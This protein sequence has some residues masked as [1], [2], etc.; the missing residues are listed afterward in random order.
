MNHDPHRP[1]NDGLDSTR[2]AMRHDLN[3]A[4]TA[5]GVILVVVLGLAIAAVFAGMR[6]AKNFERAEQAEAASRERLWNSYVAQARA[7][8]LTPQAG[9]RDA[10]L[11]VISN[12]TAI[13]RNAGLRSEA[14]ATLA[15]ADLEREQ[16][17][18]SMPRGVDQ[19]EMD[20]ALE[21]FAYGD[22]TGTVFVCRL[23]DNS[24]LQSL[25]VREAG[26]GLRQAVRS[27]AFSPD[28]TKLAA[29]F[30]GG[31]MAVWD[32][33]SATPLFISGANATNLIIAGMSFWPQSDHISFGDPDAQGLISIHDFT[34]GEKITTGIRVGARAFRFRPGTMQVAVATDNRVD[35]FAFPEETPLRTLEAAT[36]VFML[37]WTPAGDK[38]AVSTEDGDVYLWDLIRDN[39]RV[40]RGHSEPCIRLTFSPDGELLA[41]GSR[42]GTTRLWDVA[43]GQTLVLANEGL[44]HVFSADGERIGF[45][46]PSVGFGIWQLK[47]SESY[48]QLVCPKS[49][50]AFLSIDLSPSG[51]WCIATQAKGVRIWDLDHNS[52]EFFFPGPDFQSARISADESNLYVGRR[53]GLERW[54]L[55]PDAAEQPV[56]LHRAELLPL[57]DQQGARALAL[58]LASDL[59]LVE[60]TDLRLAIINLKTSA[61]PVFLAQRS[62]QTSL[63]TPGS[64]TGAGRFTLSPDGRWAVTGFGVGFGDRPKVWD[65]QTGE[66]VTELPFGSATVAFTPEGHRLGTASTA[67]FAVWDTQSWNLLHRFDRDEP[68]ISHGSLAFVRAS[69]EMAVTRTRQLA[70][71]RHALTNDTYAD[72]VAPQLQSVNS[73]RMSSDGSVLVTAS[74]TDKLQVWHLDR[75]R[76]K[77][78]PLQLDWRHPQPNTPDIAPAPAARLSPLQTTLGVSLA[79]FGLAAIFGLTTLRRHRQAIASYLAAETRTAQRNRELEMA[80]VELMHSQKMQA[81]GTLATGIAHDFNNL[82][83]V[84]RMSNKLIGRETKEHPE[85]QENVADIEQAVMQGKHVVGSMLGYARTEDETAGPTDVC[86]V[87]EETISLLSKEFLSG[88]AL[89][90]E[91]ES[92]APKVRIGRGRLE[93]VLLNLI[94]NASEAMQGKGKLKLALH[95]RSVLPAKTYALRP[96]PAAHYLEL[97]VV[98]SGPGIA[99]EVQPRLFEPFFTTKRAGAKAGTGLGLSLVFTIA[100]QDGLGLSVESEPNKGATFTIVIPILDS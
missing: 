39:Q 89:T 75:I 23:Q 47:R 35:L 37:A 30:A 87:V 59:A 76:T 27:V 63:R 44:A 12:A 81:L 22:S 52:R 77:L 83:S 42:D 3:R 36:R 38:L 45:W 67:A 55:R 95:P 2:E 66:L 53:N 50:G 7:M 19:V 96:N 91:L 31:A 51:R 64:P 17:L 1:N 98:D 90:L 97:S 18:Q 88:I 21:R 74:A 28:G 73:I 80:K 100:E 25:E 43:Q 61:P 65:T 24:V 33:P 29:R 99:P 13:R 10:V 41:T 84:I 57:P 86:A 4:N 11:N 94:V 26:P 56:D 70:Q 34:L 62:R 69:A 46:K 71:L 54:P 79:G 32:L 93:Q 20:T 82:L 85:I 6:A 49:E 16:P 92:D 5:V 68:A 72:L 40:L 58:S 14:I 8:R 48:R 9:R 60:L 78:Q 15:L